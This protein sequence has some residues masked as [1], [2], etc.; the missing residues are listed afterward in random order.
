MEFRAEYDR[1][2]E[3][4]EESLKE[5]FQEECSQRR[6]LEAMRYSLLA[7]GKRIRPV[8]L[9]KFCAASGGEME[10]AL[11]LACAIEM[12]H[13]YSLIHDDLPVMDNDDTRRGMPTC[14]KMYGECT[15]TLAGDALQAAAFRVLLSAKLHPDTLVKSGFYLA[16][17]AGETGMCGGQELDTS[18]Y[19]KRDEEGLT[20]INDLKTGALL[21][22]A[23]AI[24]VLAAGNASEE[25]MLKAAEDYGR[26][27][28][29]AFQ[30]RDDVLDITADPQVLGKP[31]GSDAENE[32]PT[33]ASVYG[34]EKCA[35]LI[36]AETQ[37]AVNSLRGVFRDIGFFEQL[38]VGL[39][40]RNY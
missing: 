14:H 21:R 5:Y 9:L 36:N 32:K 26:H 37:Q 24:G 13:T 16:Q 40:E 28:A 7:G 1:V 3:L 2:K 6:L 27:L 31:A 34:L 39:A 12:I 19:T 8:L 10:R 11:P 15:A 4:V 38:A 30:I 25:G 23:C 17:A 35:E 33:Y 22:A 29:R 20:L 18:N